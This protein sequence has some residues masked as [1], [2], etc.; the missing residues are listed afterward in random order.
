MLL[1]CAELL[2]KLT[3]CL[4]DRDSL[5]QVSAMLTPLQNSLTSAS[6]HSLAGTSNTASKRKTSDMFHR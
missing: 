2:T 3:P 6:S 4:E 1:C 5:A